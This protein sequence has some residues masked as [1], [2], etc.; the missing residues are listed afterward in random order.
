MA[1]PTYPHN[2]VKDYV[3]WI[4]DD[5]IAIAYVKDSATLNENYPR[6]RSEMGEYLSPHEAAQV[7]LHVVKKAGREGDEGNAGAM[8]E[9]THVPEF[10]SEFHEALTYKVLERLYA[11]NPATIQVAG[12]WGGKFQASINDAKKYANTGRDGVSPKI[13]PMEY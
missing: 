12:Y 1:Q 13:K 9:L 11:Q 2:I 10:P 3:W 7:R 8:T 5:K 4:E 6:D